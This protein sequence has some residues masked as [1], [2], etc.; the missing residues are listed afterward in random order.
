MRQVLDGPIGDE[1]LAAMEVHGLV[2]LAFYDSLA[3]A[4]R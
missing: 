3:L 2:G 4:L 1:I